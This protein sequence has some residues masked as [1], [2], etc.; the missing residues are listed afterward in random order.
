L[1]NQ[2]ALESLRWADEAGNSPYDTIKSKPQSIL[3][4]AVVELATGFEPATL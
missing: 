3:I 2:L 4:L 1:W